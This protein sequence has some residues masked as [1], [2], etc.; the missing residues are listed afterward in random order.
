MNIEVKN[1]MLKNWIKEVAD[2]CTPDN[3]YICNGTKEEYD[4]MV[5]QLID[6]GIAIPLD[7]RPNSYLFRSDP[8]DVARVED[9]TYIS[10]PTQEEA[11]PTNNWID[12]DALKKTMKDL[13]REMREAG[14]DGIRP[15]SP[16]R[17]VPNR[18]GSDSG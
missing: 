8:S 12:P 7:K 14:Q 6:S 3:I 2:M 9:N 13:F 5:K 17:I 11:G 10:T 18:H 4:Q 15:C 1:N 16:G